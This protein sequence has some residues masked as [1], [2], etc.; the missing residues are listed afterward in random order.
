MKDLKQDANMDEEKEVIV[1]DLTL[2]DGEWNR[3]L[4]KTLLT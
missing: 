1:V 3:R 4:L 2:E